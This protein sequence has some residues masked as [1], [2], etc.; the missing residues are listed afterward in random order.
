MD[1]KASVIRADFPA[2]RRVLAISDIHGNLAFLKE[3]LRAAGYTGADILV[4]VG[5][6]V[7]KGPDSLAVLRY[8]MELSERNAV[9]ALRGNCDDLAARLLERTWEPVPA[10]FHHYLEVW[11][12][13]SLL[14]QMARD[15]GAD[16]REPEDLPELRRRVKERLA[17]EYRFLTGMPDILET[18]EYLF[19]HGGVPREEGLEG[20]S[21]Y[22]CLKN[23]NF[24]P[25]GCAFR[26]WCVVG[27]WPVTLY[28]PRI[29]AAAPL[30]EAQRHIV[31]IDGG[32]VLKL[33]GQLNALEL[34]EAPGRPFA[35]YSYDGLPTAP[36][37][38]AQAEFAASVNIR[39]GRSQVEVLEEGPLLSRCRH[40]ETGRELDILTEFLYPKG[41][42][43][44]CE[45]STDYRPAVEPGELL[46]VVRRLPDRALVKKD[47]ATGWYFGRLGEA[48]P[49]VPR[50]WEGPPG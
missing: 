47:G 26:R 35:W 45:D 10:F 28:N 20:L 17:P 31:S 9:Y 13:R 30:F 7:E 3:L 4:L 14:V 6:L 39:W 34:P 38:D 37:L 15:T 40:L 46:T 48:G 33:D 11:Q 27:H 29:P 32:C 19:V 2:G 5:D 8:V 16:L 1:R 43:V 24:L 36:A 44:C 25:Q 50:R 41:E 42:G 18:P 49:P 23:D 22:A 12:D 21:A